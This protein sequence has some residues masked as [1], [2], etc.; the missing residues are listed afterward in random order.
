MKLPKDGLSG[1]E[2]FTGL[3]QL[4]SDDINWQE[5]RTFGYVFDPGPEVMEIGKKAYMMYLTENGLD[6]TVFQ[7]LMKLEKTLAAFGVEHMNG[8]KKAVGNF[9]SGGTESIILAV[10]A[11]RDYYR[12]KRPDINS[13]EMILPATAH[14]AFHKAAHYLGIKV[15][16][17]SVDSD[18]FRANTGRARDA[19]T[20]NTILLVGSAPSYAHGVVDPIR[21]LGEL[22]LEKD[23]W[24]HTDACMG[25]FLLP[26]LA[27]LGRQVPDF[28][29]RVPGVSSISMDLHK[30][31][32]SPKGAS[33][34]LY[35]SKDL[36]KSQIFACS[37][38]IGYTIINNAIQSSKSGGPM[39]AAWA[40]M[41]YIGDDGYLDIARKKL[42]ATQKIIRGIEA[43]P[44][45]RLLTEPDMCLVSFTSD[46]VNIFHLIDEMNSCGWYIQPALSFDNS[47]AHIHLSINASNVIWVKPFLADL[48]DAVEKVR[49]KPSGE[50]VTVIRSGLGDMNLSGL[51]DKESADLLALAGIGAGDGLPK[52]MAD[53][54]EVLDLLPPDVREKLLTTFVNDVFVYPTQ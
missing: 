53:I 26:Y 51:T 15:V 28:D 35:R 3:E 52:Q 30:Y 14:A 41:N 2:V 31:A 37:N 48:S 11:A 54:N 22:A 13:P 24:L 29:F 38:W 39:A 47:P 44:A 5:G 19:I 12:S 10:K 7:S 18:T 50:L 20:D 43:I 25:G 17:V 34:V 40:V 8:G 27:R 4:R 45:L 49:G 42:E 1:E 33:L 6:F 16:L 36:R 21:E 32:Y 23:I 9:T 46:E